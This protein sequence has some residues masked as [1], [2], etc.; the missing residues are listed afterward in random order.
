MVRA[1]GMSFEMTDPPAP[2]GS[3]QPKFDRLVC[4]GPGLYFLVYH[5]PSGE[6]VRV[7]LTSR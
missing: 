4:D 2:W 6:E 5:L 7:Q 1:M 3:C